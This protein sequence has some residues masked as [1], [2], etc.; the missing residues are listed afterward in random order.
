[1]RPTSLPAALWSGL[2]IVA[3]LSGCSSTSYTCS[4][5]GEY[6]K[7]QDKPRLA[8]PAGV[9]GGEKVTGS[10]VIPPPPKEVTKLDPPP[11][12]LDDPPSY[13]GPRKEVAADSVE[14][15]VNA[16]AASWAAKN[17]D[18]V[19]GLY[20]QQFQAG[21][22]GAG[23]SLEQRRQEVAN[24]NAPSPKLEEMNVLVAGADRRIVTFVQ[25]FG[26]NAVRK[27]LTLKREPAGWRIVAERTL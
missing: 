23:P 26:D 21:E 10:L 18:A 5:N 12:C 22:G 4:G 7:A 16:W 6:Q 2:A 13:F 17:A 8:M 1:M 24:G 20:S 25:R 14:A 15:T 19:A 11:K 9:S 27:E 3:L